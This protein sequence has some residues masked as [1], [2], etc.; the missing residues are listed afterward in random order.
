MIKP[1]SFTEGPQ[2]AH[3][4][5]DSLSEHQSD[6]F[7]L[8]R[9]KSAEAEPNDPLY[10]LENVDHPIELLQNA[11]IMELIE[12][13]YLGQYDLD[14]TT[15]ASVLASKKDIEQFI[16]DEVSYDDSEIYQSNK[17]SNLAVLECR[18]AD[19]K[20]MSVGDKVYH[21]EYVTSA[22]LGKP[23]LRKRAIEA[24][25]DADEAG[26]VLEAAQLESEAYL[27]ALDEI[28]QK[29]DHGEKLSQ[30]EL[31]LLGDYAYSSD[32]YD[33]GKA[34]KLVEYMLRRAD[35]NEGLEISVPILGA[36]TNYCA[37]NFY[38]DEEINYSSKFYIVDRFG[39]DEEV[40]TASSAHFGCVFNKQVCKDIKIGSSESLDKPR[41]LDCMDPFWVMSV[42]FHELEHDHQRNEFDRGLD[43]PLARARAMNLLT[44]NQKTC[45][46]DK[47]NGNNVGYYDANHDS[48]E[49]EI[50]ADEASW[51]QLGLLIK[52]HQ[53]KFG[54]DH[55]FYEEVL[56]KCWANEDFI[57][58]RRSLAMKIDAR[59]IPMRMAQCDIENASM[60]IANDKTG[61]VFQRF[62][63]LANYFEQD[64]SIKLNVLIDKELGG[65]EGENRDD[66]KFDNFGIELLSYI[67][68]DNDNLAKADAFLQHTKLS[69]EQ[70]KNLENNIF[71]V[72]FQDILFVRSFNEKGE[73]GLEGT[74]IGT[75]ASAEE[76]KSRQL[77][78]H[79]L[80]LFGGVLLAERAHKENPQ[81]RSY[82][83]GNAPSS[84]F[85]HYEEMKN[86]GCK[87][88]P[89]I[90]KQMYGF[91]NAQNNDVLQQVA[92]SLKEDYGSEWK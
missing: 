85:S 32:V 50:D 6:N 3:S 28:E 22:I 33:D 57:R 75:D 2:D 74:F 31:D 73:Q 54:D 40:D 36:M 20:Q 59:G 24:C 88:K 71:G 64:G 76:L 41:T 81:N 46:I 79:L 9:R 84:R 69:N 35:K 13:Q 11:E 48:E 12:S 27:K 58:S 61:K 49:I 23:E 62:P 14:Q 72:L 38:G 34:G 17:F 70:Q 82:I 19:S 65:F 10:A 66:L 39:Q 1:E 53:N 15:M 5:W 63:I 87:L 56:N 16:I 77:V 80:K 42:A 25:C 8:K 83:A 21:P 51:Y 89:A 29:F 4:E 92:R 55:S 68:I 37:K 78:D 43:T 18:I 91:C 26:Q 52:K 44:R 30:Q 67:L 60:A 90:A 45:I 86:L 47:E 7:F